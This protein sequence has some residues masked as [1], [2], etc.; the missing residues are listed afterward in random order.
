[1]SKEKIVTPKT[2]GWTF[3]ALLILLAV[4]TA[5]AYVDL[6]P[7]NLPVAMLISVAKTLIIV[8]FFMH[9]RISSSLIHLAAVCG[10]LWLMFLLVLMMADYATRGG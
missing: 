5:A 9:L 6:G 3:I 10:I 8:L 2:Y 7:F 4:T 1:M